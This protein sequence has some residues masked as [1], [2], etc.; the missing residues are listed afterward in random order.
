MKGVHVFYPNKYR[1][2]MVWD[3]NTRQYVEDDARAAEYASPL[4]LHDFDVIVAYLSILNWKKY[5]GKIYLYTND[6]GLE[7]FTKLGLAQLYDHVDTTILKDQEDKWD[8]DPNIFW[9]AHKVMVINQ[10]KAPFV[11]MD[12]DTYIEMDLT[13][14]DFYD[15][16]L[17]LFHF[18]APSLT[19]PFWT[20]IKGARD[21]PWP[22][23]WD[24]SSNAVNVG[25]VYFGNQQALKEYTDISLKFMDGNKEPSIYEQF[26]T[27]MTFAEQKILG[28]FV[29]HTDYTTSL[30][31]SGLYYPMYEN[32]NMI[33]FCDVQNLRTGIFKEEDEGIHKHSN[34][35]YAKLFLN[36]LWGYKA[37]MVVN[38]YKRLT[39]VLRLREKLKKSFPDY[40]EQ[41]EKALENW[42]YDNIK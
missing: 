33:G 28:E 35:N 23:N 17:G 1:N 18:E 37:V 14:T 21:F 20:N 34:I 24:F 5:N 36:H 16:D 40:V 10:L 30:L 41:C 9:A 8:I 11:I 2:G 32:D 7:I 15:N 25:V 42:Y 26:N 29:K 4:V 3:N 19:Y 38:M 12:F 31:I 6:I 39:F 22:D 27:R 13:E